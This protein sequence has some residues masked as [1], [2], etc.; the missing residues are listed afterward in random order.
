[1][2]MLQIRMFSI[3]LHLLALALGADAGF[4]AESYAQRLGWK[5]EDRVLILHVDDTG[6]S[7]ASNLGTIQAIEQGV[8]TSFAIMMPCPW[9]PEIVAYIR[10]HPNVDCG[11]HLTMTSEWVPYRWGPLAGKS[12]VPGMVDEQGCLWRSVQQVTEHASADEIEMEIR[13]QIERAEKLQIPITHLDSH[14]GTLFARPDYF[15]RFMKVGIEKQIPILAAGGHLTHAR[16]ENPR[17]VESLKQVVEK[18]WGAGLPVLDDL[19][20]DT[21]DWAPEDKKKMLFKVIDELQPGITEILFHASVHTEELGVIT[22][23]ARS[24]QADLDVLVD[25]DFKALIQRKGIIL[26]TWKELMVRRK[27]AK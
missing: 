10:A 26:T 3:A 27:N 16:K 22:G 14:M 4:A 7:H 19:H 20:T 24:R 1:M 12:V 13:A 15:E 2:D 9:V 6:M 17:A 25:P 8:A 21:Y 5:A 23:S 18:I 11:L